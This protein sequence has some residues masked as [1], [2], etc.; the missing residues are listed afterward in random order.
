M[1]FGIFVKTIPDL[2]GHAHLWT[3]MPLLFGE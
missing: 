1:I 2:T 3:L